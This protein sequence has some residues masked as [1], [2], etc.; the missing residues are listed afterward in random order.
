MFILDVMIEFVNEVILQEFVVLDCQTIIKKSSKNE[1]KEDIDGS[2]T[3][4]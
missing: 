4:T 1:M 3:I 2:R